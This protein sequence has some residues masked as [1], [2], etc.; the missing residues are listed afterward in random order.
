[1]DNCI[2][3]YFSIPS[4]MKVMD[5]NDFRSDPHVAV[6]HTV[7]RLCF[8]YKKL[9]VGYR[10]RRDTIYSILNIIGGNLLRSTQRSCALPP[11]IVLCT[12]LRFF[13]SGSFFMVIGDTYLLSE[14]T[15]CRCVTQVTDILVE[16]AATY[17]K[18]PSLD[19]LAEVK[20]RFYEI[21]SKFFLLN[22]YKPLL[23]DK[24]EKHK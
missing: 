24:C 16:K 8:P 4:Q 5:C 12:A 19:G 17:I 6:M 9:F 15:V 14:A 10:F 22:M 11:L 3:R 21:A 1:M 23:L 20:E 18:M 2:N 13:A 7:V